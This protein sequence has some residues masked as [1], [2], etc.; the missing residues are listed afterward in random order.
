MK[1][2]ELGPSVKSD[3]SDLLVSVVIPAFK[4]YG[5]L[6]LTLK[7]ILAQ[8]HK[9][10][11][12]LVVA[13]GDDIETRKVVA[14]QTDSRAKYLFVNH[15]GFPAVPRNEGLRQSQGDLLAFCDDDDL[16][17]PTKLAE[18]IPWLLSGEYG[19]C[20]TDYDYIDQNGALLDNVNYYQKYYGP[21]DWSTFFPSMGFICNAAGMFTREVYELVG[22]VNEDPRLRAH[23][24]FE[25]WMRVLFVCKGYFL[26]RKLVSYRIHQGS[27]QK[28]SPWKVFQN[29][30]IL[31][32]SLKKTLDIPN[33]MYARKCAKI[34]IHYLFNQFPASEKLFRVLQRRQ[35]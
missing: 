16:W 22:D 2:L 13:D 21:I 11:E 20:T 5:F 35:T 19:M 26:D 31:Q 33:A 25:Y 9:N 14:N 34:F 10:L 6:D 24:D 29:R 1:T 32:R 23:E 17:Y 30:L 28:N 27:I 4:R 12:V 7:S 18:Q 3:S 15:A 8:T